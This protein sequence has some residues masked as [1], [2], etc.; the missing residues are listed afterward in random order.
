VLLSCAGVAVCLDDSQGGNV[1]PAEKGGSAMANKV[2]TENISEA[3]NGAK[4][5]KIDIDCGTGH[6]TI[7]RLD[8]DD[9]FFVKGTLQYLQNQ[10]IPIQSLNTSDGQA[11]FMLKAGDIKKSGVHFPWTAC[12]GAYEWKIQLNP[13]VPS[14]I[15]VQSRGGNVKLNLTGMHVTALSA[16]IG[17]GNLDMVL[18]ENSVNLIATAK[19]G[20]GNLNVEVGNGTIGNSA[21]TANSGAGN[22]VVRLPDGIA[23]KVYATTGAGKVIVDPRFVKIDKNT[24]QSDDYDKAATRFDITAHSGAGN[25]SIITK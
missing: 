9:Q 21:I 24:Y 25:V 2:M 23:A 20:G 11:T 5:A 7:D 19:S 13:S 18:P 22:V 14:D 17:G 4:S 12:G 1:L 10:G 6:L 8:A 16:E 15:N 3:L